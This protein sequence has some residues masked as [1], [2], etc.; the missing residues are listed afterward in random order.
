MFD[1]PRKPAPLSP[2][3][4]QGRPLL[5]LRL[6]SAQRLRLVSVEKL[7]PRVNPEEFSRLLGELQKVEETGRTLRRDN[8]QLGQRVSDLERI[9]CNLAHRAKEYDS[10][11][12]LHEALLAQ[13]K[14]QPAFCECHSTIQQLQCRN[15]NLNDIIQQLSQQVSLLQGQ[16]DFSF[17]QKQVAESPPRTHYRVCIGR[18]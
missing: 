17:D 4:S 18:P 9:N 14:S 16:P 8:E 1:T 3:C 13:S 5:P 6:C 12:K 15:K 10:S 2:P 7:P 11:L